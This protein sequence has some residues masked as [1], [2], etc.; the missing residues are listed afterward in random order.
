MTSPPRS[1]PVGGLASPPRGLDRGG[2]RAAPLRP[3]AV[4]RP[5]VRLLRL[6]HRPRRTGAGR[7]LRRRAPR[8]SSRRS[9]TCSRRHR[10]RSS[11]AAA[12]RPSRSRPHLARLL[13]AL[14]PTQELTVEANPETITP[15]LAALL[16]EHGV[17]RVS[18]GAQSFQPHLLDVARAPGDARDRARAPSARCATPASTT[19]RSTSIYGIPGQSPDDLAGRSRGGARARA[20][21]TCPATSSRRSRAR[22]SRTRTGRSSPAQADAMESVLRAR[23]RD[24]HD[25]RLP[26][27]RDRELLSCRRRSR[28]AGTAQ[29]RLLA[30]PR[31]PR[32]RH[33]RGL[34][35]RGLRWRN[36]PGLPRYLAAA[37]A[38]RASP[39]RELEPLEDD[40]TSTRA[41]AARS[42]T[43]RAAPDRRPGRTPSTRAALDRLRR[44]GLVRGSVEAGELALTPRGRFLGG[45]VTAELLA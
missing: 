34:H 33:R 3:P 40:D 24:A 32:R 11:S 6:R 16:R 27:V 43:R 45:G 31:L 12:R 1:V 35:G 4:L 22:A 2:A 21:S 20:P 28:P 37:R 15:A 10:R 25:R 30:R 29:P 19:S 38:R 39:P 26:L 13:A 41:R 7:G 44:L 8:R 17:N 18:L 5:P 9:A 14:P 42:P 23:R 36:A